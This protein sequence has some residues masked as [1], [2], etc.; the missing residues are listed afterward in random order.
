MR[1]RLAGTVVALALATLL[2]SR[3]PHAQEVPAGQDFEQIERGR[4]L[5]VVG[6][7]GAC[8]TADPRAPF[9]GGRPIETPFGNVI[10]PNITPDLGTG[11]GGWS[12]DQFDAALRRGLRP[13]GKRLYPAMP[14]AYY[15]R[16]TRSDVLAMRAYL[17]TVRPVRNEVHADQLP[18][19]FNI[20]TVMAV[21][22]G[23]YF[24]PGVY[25]TDPQQS[26]DWNRGAYLVL[27]AGHCAACHTPK[28]LM[29][30]DKNRDAFEGYNLQGWFAPDITNDAADGLGRWSAQDI[31]RYLKTGHNRYSA[32]SG[33]M[34][35]EVLDS[36]SHW[37]PGDLTAVALYLKNQHGEP[38]A[39]AG[40]AQAAAAAA[41]PVSGTALAA[42]D[43]RMV[44]GAA[45]YS[46]LCSACH[47][48]DGTGVPYMIPN[49]AASP[50]V[51]QRDA[52]TLIR[53]VL[54]GGRSV[55]TQEEPTDAMMPSFGWQL[56][57]EEVAAVTTFIRNSWGHAAPAVSA[58][59]VHSARESLRPGARD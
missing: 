34:G 55:A 52:A 37:S 1:A 25:Q 41:P 51:A 38:G 11:I 18:F 23:L 33:P 17:N 9:A 31:V 50:N 49:L 24:S 27:G 22:D 40:N 12:D 35:E 8:H 19:P 20:R 26:S 28:T 48:P 7:C 2:G 43:E 36:S 16:M 46:D 39:G 58:A 32:A 10:A 53:V 42:N 15:T 5:V 3:S 29:G 57:D 6:D 47:A 4:Y 54:Q 45:I 14:Y 30:G 21:W 13:D 59:D 56:T 44:A